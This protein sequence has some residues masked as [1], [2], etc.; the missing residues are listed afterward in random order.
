[1]SQD[2]LTR[3]FMRPG[4]AY[5]WPW[6]MFPMGTFHVSG[7]PENE[8]MV[9]QNGKDGS[10]LEIEDLKKKVEHLE[11]RLNKSHKKRS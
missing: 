5:G 10:A 1:M 2:F 4:G 9:S 8:M 7:P 6:P 3:D 11:K